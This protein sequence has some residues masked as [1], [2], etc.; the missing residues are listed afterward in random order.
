MSVASGEDPARGSGSLSRDLCV[1]GP[2]SGTR[3]GVRG[4]VASER[5]HRLHLLSRQL[6]GGPRDRAASPCRVAPMPLATPLTDMAAGSL[7]PLTVCRGPPGSGRRLS[8]DTAG[9]ARTSPCRTRLTPA[10][11]CQEAS[12]P[13][14]PGGASV[15]PPGRRALGRLSVRGAR[16]KLLSARVGLGQQPPRGERPQAAGL[17][18]PPS[19][20]SLQVASCSGCCSVPF[21]LCRARGQRKRVPC[22]RAPEGREGDRLLPRS[23]LV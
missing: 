8:G 9:G 14:V 16:Q 7:P 23:C 6:V 19:G 22:P 17:W 5:R 20:P 15:Q 2:S 13:H 12:R 4:G 3:G 11:G 18:W 10:A 1:P 21:L